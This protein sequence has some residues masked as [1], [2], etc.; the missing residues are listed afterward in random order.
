MF[1]K[2]PALKTNSGILYLKMPEEWS[3]LEDFMIIDLNEKNAREYLNI[4]DRVLSGKS[5]K[6]T[7]NGNSTYLEILKDKATIC[8]S[9][10]DCECVILTS[11]LKGILEAYIRECVQSRHKEELEITLQPK[12]LPS[13]QIPVRT[14]TLVLGGLQD[15]TDSVANTFFNQASNRGPIPQEI[16]DSN[17]WVLKNVKAGSFITELELNHD[18]QLPFDEIPQKQIISELFNLFNASNEEDSLLDAVSSLGTRSLNKYKEWIKNIQDL[19]TPIMLNWVTAADGPISSRFDK[20]KASRVYTIL[21]EKL[22]R[23]EVEVSLDGRLTMVHVRT[24]AFE[25][26]MED[27]QKIIGK[28]SK[29]AFDDSIKLLNQRCYA[30]LTKITTVS[31]VGKEKIS[32]VL[33][34]LE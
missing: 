17:S 23:D 10:T 8:N 20:E 5:D 29:E 19:D 30:L 3:I 33:N 15:I 27:G 2:Y 32:W 31:S 26:C 22:K 25:I 24:S 12:E 7:L 1:S 4:V 14:L 13:G 9:P 28:I 34:S 18:A 6:E 16:K 21:D 11:D